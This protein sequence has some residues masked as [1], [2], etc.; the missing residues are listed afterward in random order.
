MLKDMIY[1]GIGMG[2]LLKEKV[3]N[4]VKKLED[5]GKIKTD[6]AKT[7]IDSL[8]TK[9]KDEEQRIR[10]MF[11]DTIKEVIDE[12]GI[13]TKDDIKKIKKELSKN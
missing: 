8:S 12:L 10:D 4:E 13:A 7:F 2:V 3:E 5:E 6:D 11:K 1:T 9:G